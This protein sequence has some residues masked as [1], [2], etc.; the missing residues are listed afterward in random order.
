LAKGRTTEQSNRSYL[1]WHIVTCLLLIILVAGIQAQGLWQSRQ[2]AE[3]RTKLVARDLGN[4]LAGSIAGAFENIDLVLLAAVDQ[5]RSR[6]VAVGTSDGPS[7]DA[8]NE[9]HSRTPGLIGLH[10]TDASGTVEFG[11]E[12]EVAERLSIA[13]RDYFQRLKADPNAGMVVSSPVMGKIAKKWV[14]VCARRIDL[15]NGQFDGVVYGS[16]VID[17][18]ADRIAGKRLQLGDNDTVAV[19]TNAMMLIVRY[20]NGHQDMQFVGQTRSVPAVDELLRSGAEEG[21]FSANSPFDQVE[22]IFYFERIAGQPMNLIV[23]LAT[24]DAMSGWRRETA[25]AALT[26]AIFAL[27]VSFGSFL[28]Y[29]GQVRKLLL[30]AELAGSNQRL[31]DLSTTDGL[32]G[33]ANRRRFDALL[34]EEWLRGIRNRQALA[35]A[36][37]DIDYFKNYNDRYGHPGGDECLRKV[38]QLL[39]QHVRRAG[40]FVA[41][42]GG[43]EF[44]IVC[45]ATEGENARQLVERIRV[46]LEKAAL[47]HETSPFGHVTVSIGVAAMVPGDGQRSEILIRKADEA[48]YA[49]KDAG[50]NRVVL[51]N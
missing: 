15:P 28:I 12:Q 16:I 46:S 25:Y 20:I 29:Q 5:V 33:I 37:V 11:S 8:L 13:D 14:L 44:A 21:F 1:I 26:T 4:V 22:R 27:I 36:M 35:L 10:A 23:G 18:M 39:R 30:V 9:M 32:T 43:E 45:L 42:Y 3:E 7:L 50:R 24:A 17:G 34:S 38:A 19:S 31:S 51:A 41:R 49:A 48:L 40:D 2:Q 47:P 6:R